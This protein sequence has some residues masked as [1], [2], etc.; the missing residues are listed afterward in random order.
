MYTFTARQDRLAFL[1]EKITWKKI[2]SQYE[3]VK[4]RKENPRM[5]CIV[6]RDVYITFNIFENISSLV[7]AKIKKKKLF[8]AIVCQEV[9][10]SVCAFLTA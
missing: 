1:R 7:D 8:I 4:M 9:F 3:N 10:Y 6:K 5:I 2:H